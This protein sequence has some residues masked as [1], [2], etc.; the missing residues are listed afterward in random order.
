MTAPQGATATI[1]L[2][3]GRGPLVIPEM[4]SSRMAVASTSSATR[5]KAAFLQAALLCVETPE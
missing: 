1:G 5:S 2:D 4:Q 3:A